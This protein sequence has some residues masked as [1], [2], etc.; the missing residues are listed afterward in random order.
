MASAICL[1][2][3]RSQNSDLVRS[4]PYPMLALGAW[5]TNCIC[6]H[7]GAVDPRT[8]IPSMPK[9]LISNAV[10]A[11]TPQLGLSFLYFSY[12][13]LFTAML[14]GYEWISY[15]HK[16]KGLRV[17]HKPSGAQRFTYFLQLPYRFGIP[18]MIL[19][20]TLYVISM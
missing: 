3:Q 18:L 5:F 9:G 11:N 2:V 14:M 20:V 10:I 12:N 1:P 16:R 17:T 15:S 13:A 7:L 4:G 8:A 6:D 19:S